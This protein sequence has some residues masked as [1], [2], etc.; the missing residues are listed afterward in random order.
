MI[1]TALLFLAQTP[2]PQAAPP[3]T[4]GLL[5]PMICIFV[6]MYFLI[7]RPQSKKQKALANMI[8]ELKTGDHVVTSGGI[9]GVVAN[10][11]EGSVLSLRIAD[12]VK[13]DVDKAA[14]AAVDRGSE[15]V[16]SK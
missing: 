8:S 9:H 6:I 2:A 4:G 13:I 12:N 16:A 7:I 15:V 10:I 14:I 1:S 3:P 5:I 11:K